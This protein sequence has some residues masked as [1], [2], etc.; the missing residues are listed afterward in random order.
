M[1]YGPY[2]QGPGDYIIGLFMCIQFISGRHYILLT[3]LFVP[4][5]CLRMTFS[6]KSF[7]CIILVNKHL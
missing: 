3:F 4:D 7:K 1:Q 5:W 6:C 2:P